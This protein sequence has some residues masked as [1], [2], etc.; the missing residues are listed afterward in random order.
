VPSIHV[1]KNCAPGSLTGRHDRTPA[2]A[3]RRLGDLA[4]E[5]VTY[6][7]YRGEEFSAVVRQV[8]GPG[9]IAPL[10]EEPRP[11]LPITSLPAPWGPIPVRQGRAGHSASELVTFAKCQ[12]KHWFIYGMGLREPGVPGGGRSELPGFID[13]VTRG[14]IVHDV[15]EELRELDELDLV[16]EDAIGRW[17]PDAPAPDGVE[18]GRYRARLRE[19]IERV[20]RHSDYRAVADLPGARRELGFV[21]LLGD[22]RVMQGVFDLA[23]PTADGRLEVLDVK[24]GPAAALSWKA[25]ASRAEGY[26][27][28]RDVY[29]LAAEAISG[30][31][32]GRFAFHFSGSNRQVASDITPELRARAEREVGSML[33]RIEAGARELTAKPAECR[34]CGFRRVGWCEGV[35]RRGGVR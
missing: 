35:A 4:G 28:Q 29:V 1:V 27:P 9:A 13:A 3:I 26:A 33:E 7:N 5:T 25:V 23:A 20:A 11:V 17:D 30:L 6:R 16:L 24:T 14:Q 15:L 19:E 18:G 31:A 12:R 2:R 22:G 34:F 10:S 8:S 32:V 21:H